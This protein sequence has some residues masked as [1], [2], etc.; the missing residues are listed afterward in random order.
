MHD[1]WEGGSIGPYA[2]ILEA[3]TEMNKALEP[4]K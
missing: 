4:K 2:T 3:D 1:F